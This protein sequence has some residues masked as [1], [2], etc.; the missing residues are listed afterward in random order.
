MDKTTTIETIH[1]T[2]VHEF[3]CDECGAYLGKS[4]EYD[5]GYYPEIGEF[6]ITVNINGWYILKE[7]LCD[8]CAEKKT[9][10]IYKA[11]KNLGFKYD[12]RHFK[13]RNS[14]IPEIFKDAICNY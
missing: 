5:D 1:K 6:E 11:L 14:K 13:D 12:S 4:E 10:D 2:I 3:Y 8:K 7:C 9:N